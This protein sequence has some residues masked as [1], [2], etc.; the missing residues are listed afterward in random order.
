ML[1]LPS[2][3]AGNAQYQTPRDK[4]T[5]IT[6]R[7]QLGKPGYQMAKAKSQDCNESQGICSQ[8]SRGQGRS[9]GS[10]MPDAVIFLVG[11]E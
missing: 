9:V 7:Q 6:E 5:Q 1:R 2:Q 3:S 11:L 8:A 10:I 4:H